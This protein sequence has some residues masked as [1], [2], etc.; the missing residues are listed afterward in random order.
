MGATT[1]Q[2][3][4]YI[5]PSNYIA[6]PMTLSNAQ[7]RNTMFLNTADIITIEHVPQEPNKCTS[8]L[9]QARE[10]PYRKLH[11]RDARKRYFRR[12]MRLPIIDLQLQR[13]SE[14]TRRNVT[15][16]LAQCLSPA[17]ARYWLSPRANLRPMKSFPRRQFWASLLIID[18]P[19]VE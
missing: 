18:G 9:R 10:I 4:E 14:E 2:H 12:C 11:T 5:Q 16:A 7:S 6:R 1:D 13:S 15:S 3:Q 8:V 17:L 19:K